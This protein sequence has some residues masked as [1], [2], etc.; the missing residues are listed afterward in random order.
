MGVFFS[1]T[2]GLKIPPKTFG[3]GKTQGFGVSAH[4]K[5]GKKSGGPQGTHNPP[6]PL[7]GFRDFFLAG[8]K[9]GGWGS[10]KHLVS[11]FFFNLFAA[12]PPQFI[13]LL[14]FFKG[15]VFPNFLGGGGKK[16]I[17]LQIQRGFLLSFERGGGGLWVF[18]RGLFPIFG[19]GKKI[20]FFFFLF[21]LWKKLPN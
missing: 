18:N 9:E 21:F 10:F 12:F 5:K 19:D 3:R 8:K 15:W 20:G 14:N 7:F 17:F 6:S 2:V 4:L 16:F 11:L 1:W 13:G